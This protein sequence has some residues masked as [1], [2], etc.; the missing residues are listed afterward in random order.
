MSKTQIKNLTPRH[1]VILDF[2]I[3][4]PSLKRGEIAREFGVTE[5]WLSTIIHSDIFQARL[6]DRQD[7][8]F[9]EAIVP[10][11]AKIEALAYKALDVVEDHLNLQPSAELGLRTAELALKNS[12]FGTRANLSNSG[13]GLNV[14]NANII[15]A[16]PQM[17]A[18]ARERLGAV[19][20]PSEQPTLPSPT[21]GESQ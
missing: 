18:R 21:I 16:D 20:S 15:I 4:N 12:V 10:L 1:D 14:E 13:A 9:S 6:A 8:F 11:S 5:A 17:L 19:A 2:L 7:E 3:S